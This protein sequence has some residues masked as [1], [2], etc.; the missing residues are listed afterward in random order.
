MYILHRTLT[1]LSPSNCLSLEIR[2][3]AQNALA[4]PGLTHAGPK[5]FE[6]INK[7]MMRQT[8]N[9]SPW[10]FVFYLVILS[11]IQVV[12]SSYLYIFNSTPIT[13]REYI[14]FILTLDHLTSFLNFRSSTD[15]N[16]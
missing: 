9:V 6:R 8:R 4:L 13:M 11:P 5:H 7:I 14:L 2:S 1:P 15:T 16:T 10:S 3:H 12:L